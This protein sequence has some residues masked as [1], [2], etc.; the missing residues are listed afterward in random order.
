MFHTFFYEPIYNLLVIFLKIIPDLGVAIIFI[1]LLIRLLLLPLNLRAQEGQYI[2]KELEGELK[3]L[4]E[5]FGKD[6]KVYAEKIMELYKQRGINPFSSFFLL[7]IQI[8]IFLALYFVFTEPV[9]LDTNSIYF[10]LEFPNNLKELAFG[11]LNLSQNNLYIGILTG[12]T[13]FI[14]SKKQVATNQRISEV[15]KHKNQK[16]SGENKDDR[17]DN[18]KNGIKNLNNP[19]SFAEIF[20]KNINFQMVYFFPIISGFAAA[21]L[22]A[23]LGIYWTTSNVINFLQDIYIKKKLDIEGFIKKHSQ[24]KK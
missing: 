12:V 11:F 1:T 16:D 15:F 17:Q 4:K 7:I 14:Y 10:F 9:K 23:A 6:K 3:S 21:Y 8:P 5:K 20:V 13:M 2:M 22:P 24:L 19:E 18:K